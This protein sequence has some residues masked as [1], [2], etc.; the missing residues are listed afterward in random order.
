VKFNASQADYLSFPDLLDSA[1][2]ALDF[3][4]CYIGGSSKYSKVMPFRVKSVCAEPLLLTFKSNLASQVQL[5]SNNLTNDFLFA[6]QDRVH[7]SICILAGEIHKI[8]TGM[9]ISLRSC[10]SRTRL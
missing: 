10:S 4:Y 1:A 7:I 9:L 3:G 2:P 8:P 6:L 5:E